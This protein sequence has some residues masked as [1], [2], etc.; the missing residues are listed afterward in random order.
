MTEGN[1]NPNCPEQYKMWPLPTCEEQRVPQY[2]VKLKDAAAAVAAWKLIASRLYSV[3]GCHKTE[4]RRI[5][6]EAARP[7]SAAPRQRGWSA[8]K[9]IE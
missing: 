6:A 2:D 7:S 5:A 9:G 3:R 8:T 1:S 4:L